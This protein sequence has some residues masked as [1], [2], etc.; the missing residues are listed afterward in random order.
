MK[1]NNNRCSNFGVNNGGGP[2]NLHKLENPMKNVELVIYLDTY[3]R[4]I[5]RHDLYV[6]W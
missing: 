4:Y 1:E 6:Q 3:M 2:S 5:E